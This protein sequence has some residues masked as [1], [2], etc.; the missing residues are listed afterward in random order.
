VVLMTKMSLDLQ[1]QEMDK[2]KQAREVSNTDPHCLKGSSGSQLMS[3]IITD[4]LLLGQLN[5]CGDV[6]NGKQ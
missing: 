2:E 6:S 3:D 1:L 5:S 4:S